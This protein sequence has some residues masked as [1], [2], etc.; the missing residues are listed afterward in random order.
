MC[1]HITG[2]CSMSYNVYLMLL[3]FCG[4]SIILCQETSAESIALRF[5]GLLITEDTFTLEG[6]KASILVDGR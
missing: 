1:P 6:I 3:N 4:L 2:T 5:L